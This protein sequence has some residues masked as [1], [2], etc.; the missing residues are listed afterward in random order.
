MG[1]VLNVLERTIRYYSTVDKTEDKR[2]HRT[3][4]L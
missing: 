2:T 1:N 3:T 4:T